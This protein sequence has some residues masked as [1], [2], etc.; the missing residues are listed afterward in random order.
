MPDSDF[1]YEQLQDTGR[2]PS[3]VT[4]F[5][6]P[7]SASKILRELKVGDS[8]VVDTRRGR[9]SIIASA[10]RLEIPITVRKEG[11]KF[12]VTRLP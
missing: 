2:R 4:S 9:A 3:A 5:G 7:L 10:W 12:R 8:F 6:I 11:E 1:Q